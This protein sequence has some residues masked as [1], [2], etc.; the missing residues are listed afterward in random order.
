MQQLLSFVSVLQNS[1][2]WNIDTFLEKSSCFIQA[3][4]RYSPGQ[5]LP[6]QS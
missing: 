2:S 1:V 5:H 6:A 3:A 4:D